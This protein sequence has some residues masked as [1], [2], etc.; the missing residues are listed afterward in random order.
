MAIR[1]PVITPDG[2]ISKEV[3]FLIVD[4][5]DKIVGA[6][7]NNKD[8]MIIEFLDKVSPIIIWH[9]EE[10]RFEF[11]AEIFSR[12]PKEALNKIVK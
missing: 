12:D 8:K 2:K 9:K 6:V 10:K 7:F 11:D 1:P 3:T 5:T 4:K